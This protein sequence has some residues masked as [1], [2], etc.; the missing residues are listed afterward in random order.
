MYHLCPWLI[1]QSHFSSIL[2]MISACQAESFTYIIQ[3]MHMLGQILSL[4]NFQNGRMGKY[5]YFLNRVVKNLVYHRMPRIYLFKIKSHHIFFPNW[6]SVNIAKIWKLNF[7]H[8]NQYW[9]KLA[10]ILQKC[11]EYF[12]N[13]DRP[14]FWRKIWCFFKFK[15]IYVWHF[16]GTRGFALLQFFQEISTRLDWYILARIS[17]TY[18][19]TSRYVRTATDVRMYRYVRTATYVRT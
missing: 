15:R 7:L 11:F 16:Y 18:V 8:T 9:A 5:K 6:W 14:S 12:C 17:L 3:P 1:S 2:A 10:K 13:I 19:S 4:S